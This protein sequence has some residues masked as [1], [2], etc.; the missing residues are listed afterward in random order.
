MEDRN[1]I[2]GRRALCAENLHKFSTPTRWCVND[3]KGRLKSTDQALWAISVT[4]EDNTLKISGV[5]LKVACVR[6]ASRE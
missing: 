6:S 2:A 3:D 4:D 1:K 5:R